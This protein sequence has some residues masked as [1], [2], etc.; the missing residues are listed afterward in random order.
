MSLSA[1]FN[2]A[3]NIFSNASK[4]FATIVGNIESSDNKNYVCRDA[5]TSINP[6]GVKVV[7]QRSENKNMFDKLLDAHSSVA[8]QQR[9]LESFE[10]LKGIMGADNQY[11]NSPT[12]HISK[13]RDSLSSY[14]KNLPKNIWGKQVIDDSEL[15]VHN[16]NHSAKE[17]QKI[18]ADADKEIDLEISNLKVLL[19]EFKFINDN[20]KL[21]TAV[22]NDANDFLDKRD[23]LLQKISEII[24][25]STIVRNKND[26]VIYTSDG[27]TLFETVPRDINFEKMDVYTATSK[28]NPVFVDGVVISPDK[29]SFAQQGKIKSLLQ[30]RDSVVPMFQN[31]LDEMARSLISCFS[32]KDQVAG[33]SKDIPGLFIA[34][35]IKTLDDSN[36]IHIGIST[37]ISIN[38]KYRSNPLFLRDGGSTSNNFLWNVKGSE[39]YSDLINHY[40]D[41]FNKIFSFNSEAG[42]STN[43]SLLEYARNSIGWLEK[44]RSD[45]HDFNMKNKVVLNHISES[46]SNTTGVNLQ[47]ELSFLIKVEQSY[48]IS[49]KLIMS[50]NRMLQTLLEG[51]K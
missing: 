13:L 11:N 38:P 40:C 37:T 51:V 50:I 48:N 18:R 30:I 22:N 44:N 31:Q 47:E 10:A 7:I 25:I 19:S 39:G 49:N 4:Q 42:I 23:A 24:G 26:M 14:S 3:Q 28:S 46:Y 34:D 20:I 16:L 41:S 32:E 33:R 15:V 5:M 21:K 35:G 45:S 17:I 36:K 8:G 27:A 29:E 1:V 2:K 12:Y 6:E 43:V 9:I